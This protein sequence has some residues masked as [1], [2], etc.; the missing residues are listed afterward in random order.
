MYSVPHSALSEVWCWHIMWAAPNTYEVCPQNE[1]LHN[2]HSLKGKWILNTI[3]T[4]QMSKWFFC[5]IYIFSELNYKILIFF[6]KL[7]I[8]SIGEIIVC[9]IYK[10]SLLRPPNANRSRQSKFFSKIVRSILHSKVSVKSE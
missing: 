8:T 7:E 10:H 5:I 6:W 9:Q 1:I 2:C 4:E 3:T